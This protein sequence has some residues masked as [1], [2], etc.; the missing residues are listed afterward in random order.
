MRVMT[1]SLSYTLRIVLASLMFATVFLMLSMT[2]S[3]PVEAFLHP[4]PTV[5]Y[6]IEGGK[7]TYGFWNAMARSWYYNKDVNHRSTVEVNG[8]KLRSQC[9]P[10]VM[11]L[12][13]RRGL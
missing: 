4:G 2:I 11:N 9:T 10:L 12:E 1:T 3:K 5:Q 8:E 13:L 6:P 7:W